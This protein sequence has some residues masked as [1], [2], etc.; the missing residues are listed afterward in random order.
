MENLSMLRNYFL[1]NVIFTSFDI[2]HLF[3]WRTLCGVKVYIER[4]IR[5]KSLWYPT[6]R[7]FQPARIFLLCE[8]HFPWIAIVGS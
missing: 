1:S 2:K 5:R 7:I 6:R 4:K 8:N 3:V